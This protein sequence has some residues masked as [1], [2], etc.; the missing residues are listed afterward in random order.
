[1]STT[2]VDRLITHIRNIT[3]NSSTNSVEDIT[4]EEIIRFINQA[5]RRIQSKIVEKDPMSFVKET[6]INSVAGQEEY[7]L[8]EDLMMD[9][10]IISAEYSTDNGDDT[11]YKLR[12][13][14]LKHQQSD[15]DGLPK[16]YIR[17]NKLDTD[18]AS[19]LLSPVP[20]SSSEKIRLVYTKN[21]EDLDIRRG[22]VSAVTDSGTAITAL[23]LDVS[24]TPPIDDEDLGDHDYF[25][26]VDKLGNMKM[27]NLQFDSINTSTGVVTL[28][29][30]S[31]T[32]STGES[33][34]VGDY[35]VGG[36]ETTTHSRLPLFIEEYIIEYAALKIMH[37]DSNTD[38]AEQFPLLSAMEQDIVSKFAEPTDDIMFLEDLSET[39][40]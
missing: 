31:H 10:R 25:C 33:I 9:S 32:Y 7:N 21:T 38:L 11:Y 1:M 29:D 30:S 12:P 18:T 6:L 24:G 19:I 2:R 14:L 35:I 3:K 23:T 34:A 16:W 13:G 22:V 15:V 39:L 28:T 4:D 8:P 37:R 40:Y 36:R 20:S 17:R 5:Q 26:V 27:R